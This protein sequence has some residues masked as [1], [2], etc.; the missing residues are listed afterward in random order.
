[1]SPPD[2]ILWCVDS[3]Q[4]HAAADIN[5]SSCFALQH[6]RSKSGLETAP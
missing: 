4:P 6:G 1:M 2:N 5:D 3:A